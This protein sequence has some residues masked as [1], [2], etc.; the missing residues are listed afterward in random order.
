MRHKNGTFAAGSAERHRHGMARSRI[1]GVWRSMRSRCENPNVKAYSDYGARG[2]T[3]CERWHDFA[4]F[5]ADMGD[6]P[7]GMTLDRIDND[8]GYSP[9]NCRWASRTEQS[10][11][12]R[13]LR[14]MTAFGATRSM[15]EWSELTG[16]KLSTIW[17][18]IKLGWSDEEALSRPIR[19]CSRWSEPQPIAA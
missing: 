5:Y 4:N 8:C 2:I 13:G 10:R 7:A 17:N 18:R 1:Y 19:K 3:V 11:N 14:M 15:G 9:N 16:I 6:C 12:Q